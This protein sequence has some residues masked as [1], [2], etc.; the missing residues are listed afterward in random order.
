MH[1]APPP[2]ITWRR[3]SPLMIVTSLLALC[4]AQGCFTQATDCTQ[5]D[6]C[7]VGEVCSEG[8]CVAGMT[9]VDMP[10]SDSGQ[11]DMTPDADLAGDMPVDAG[12]EDMAADLGGEDMASDLGRDMADM[13]Q[14]MPGDMPPDV[15][16]REPTP[17]D[18]SAPERVVFG[19]I[20][21]NTSEQQLFT[22][23]N[24]GELPLAITSI[25]VDGMMSPFTLSYPDANAPGDPGMD[26]ATPPASV[27][28]NGSFDVRVTFSP[29]ST[30]P[31]DDALTI[32][33]DDPDQGSLSVA[34]E[35]NKPK[36]CV[37]LDLTPGT[38]RDYTL[39]F[40]AITIGED[41]S[42]LVTAR[43]CSMTRD[44]SLDQLTITNSDGGVFDIGQDTANALPIALLPGE[45]ADLELVYNP[46][47]DFTNNGEVVLTSTLL[48]AQTTEETTSIE[49]R[50]KGTS[51]ICPAAAASAREITMVTP[52][53]GT[54]N[55]E[56]LKTIQLDGT[57]STP[58]GGAPITRYEW[59]L[60][61]KPG[62]SSSTISNA[63]ASQ[64]TIFLDHVGT[65]VVELNVYNQSNQPSC[66]RDR[67]YI[68]AVPAGDIYLELFWEAP[69]A[70]N[71][72]DP[73]NGTDLD[74]HFKRDQGAWNMAPDDVYWF[75]PTADWGAIGPDE[76]PVFL[77]DD[78]DGYGP[79]A[80][81]HEDAS[82]FEEYTIG[83]YLYD[84]GS[85]SDFDPRVNVYIN[86]TLDS[87]V[88]FGAPYLSDSEPFWIVGT[89]QTSRAD[90]FIE[91]GTPGTR[92][93]FSNFP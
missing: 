27:E 93:T 46:S 68:E 29:T 18:I 51:T 85:I 84:R 24:N 22:I 2:E 45:E 62:G 79:E 25:T 69:T 56:P 21:P 90:V 23:E 12:E 33:S 52:T 59:T 20:T 9:P 38:T 64:P 39:D 91:D 49:L 41:A 57:A 67:L 66:N 75:N 43:N 15:D 87:S 6:D 86:G 40:G 47:M 28:G 44:L 31:I 73:Q 11:S 1:V 7:F 3:S 70:V 10:A 35:G 60:L 82:L 5:D 32:E 14:D 13:R 83:V 4:C 36:P 16:M 19:E 34:L 89:I 61:S 58:E 26:S 48:P 88:A 72:R 17:Q 78:D 71:P 8:A 30:D 63:Q 80:L 76:N 37:E 54:L 55:T 53:M 81:S 65:Y 77:L 74:L 92:S 50:G 42:R